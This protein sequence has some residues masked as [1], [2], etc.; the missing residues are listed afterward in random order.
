MNTTHRT[1]FPPRLLTLLIHEASLTPCETR[2]RRTAYLP[3]PLLCRLPHVFAMAFHSLPVGLVWPP[4]VAADR[5]PFARKLSHDRNAASQ[6]S[7]LLAVRSLMFRASGNHD[8]GNGRLGEE[9]VAGAFSSSLRRSC[10]GSFVQTRSQALLGGLGKDRHILSGSGHLYII[11]TGDQIESNGSDPMTMTRNQGTHFR[12]TGA[13]LRFL[14]VL[15]LPINLSWPLF[16]T[17]LLVMVRECLMRGLA[18]RA[19][20]G[21][22]PSYIMQGNI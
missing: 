21:P 2:D 10:L 19:R 15:Y 13:S 18:R 14:D 22:S 4:R 1:H 7:R 5:F 20:L 12:V 8:M 16:H 11:K 3:L 17:Q 9:K 6:P